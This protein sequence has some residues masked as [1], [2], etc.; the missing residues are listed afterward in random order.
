M[1]TDVLTTNG[2]SAMRS[3]LAATLALV[4]CTPSI[5]Q[6]KLTIRGHVLKPDSKPLAGAHITIATAAV[7]RG[8]SP[9]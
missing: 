6:E 3:L 2:G 7:R 9:Y 8:T 1:E 4:A 5:A